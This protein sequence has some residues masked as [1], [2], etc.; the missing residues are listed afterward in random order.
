MEKERISD[1]PT[2]HSEFLPAPKQDDVKSWEQSQARGWKS[3]TST[4]SPPCLSLLFSP[5]S[6]PVLYLWFNENLTNLILHIGSCGSCICWKRDVDYVV[7]LGHTLSNTAQVKDSPELL[8]PGKWQGPQEREDE[9]SGL[10]KD[11]ETFLGGKF[12][13]GFM[14]KIRS[15]I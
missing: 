9:W 2:N 14:K 3:S 8:S 10:R 1:R 5:L 11:Q 12:G 4:S 6:S 7:G 13:R 15:W